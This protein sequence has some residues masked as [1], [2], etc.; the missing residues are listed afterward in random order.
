M[1]QMHEHDITGMQKNILIWN[2][3]FFGFFLPKVIFVLQKKIISTI[4]IN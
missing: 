2:L 3:L 4:L 1:L